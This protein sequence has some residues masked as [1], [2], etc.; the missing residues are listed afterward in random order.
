MFTGLPKDPMILLSVVNTKLR[1]FYHSLDEMCEDM[2][3]DR[4]ELTEKLS[5]ID[6]EYD[7]QRNQFV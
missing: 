7:A 2:Q 6:Y 1:D 5:S 4:E 3:I